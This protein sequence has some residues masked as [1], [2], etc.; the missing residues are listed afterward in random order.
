MSPAVAQ[1]SPSPSPTESPA[2]PSPS[3]AP[4]KVACE[5]GGSGG[6]MVMI[7]GSFTQQQ[8]LYDVSDPA[9]PR[10]LCSFANTSARIFTGD[11]VEWLKPT[12]ANETDVVLHSL[13]SGNDS[14]AGTFPFPVTSGAWLPD[15]SVMAYT[16]P[17]AADDNFIGG[18]TQVW[19]YSQHQTALLYTYRNGIGDCICRF[20]LPPPVLAISPD[21]RYVV[22]GWIVGKGAEPLAIYRVSDRT[23][24]NS[25]DP[26][27]YHAFWDR[28]GHRLFLN[29]SGNVAAEVWTPESGLVALAGAAAWS[30]LPGLSPDG[31]Q[32]AYTAYADPNAFQN[33][34]TYVYDLK[35]GSTRMLI[36]KLRSQALFVKSGWVWYLDEVACDPTTCGAPWGTQPSGK[37]FAMQLTT[38]AET[39]VS[40]AIGEDPVTQAGGINWLAFGPGEFWPDN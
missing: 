29:R 30:Y 40:F 15:L 34:R 28:S 14:V 19:L 6:S 21:G 38:G 22:A 7:Q 18:G 9:H 23:R 12:S 3:P 32:V 39:P 1:A 25:L 36:D 24:V 13:G 2:T 5:G 11:T 4:L 20:G 26:S 35:G 37:V 8:L 27:I 31:N 33:L 17:V 10:L 16:I